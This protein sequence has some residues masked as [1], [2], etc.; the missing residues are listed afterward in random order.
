MTKVALPPL[1]F[2][3]ERLSFTKIMLHIYLEDQQIPLFANSPIKP[4]LLSVT[5]N[6]SPQGIIP[7]ELVYVGGGS[8]DLCRTYKAV[9]L[10][11]A[12]PT[13]L[14]AIFSIWGSD[15]WHCSM[16]NHAAIHRSQKHVN[17]SIT[18]VAN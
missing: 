5:H 14:V 7:R 16:P 4:S 2:T 13:D 12:R 6:S 11:E 10:S 8:L 18:N 1:T 15:T 9:K 3:R 17:G